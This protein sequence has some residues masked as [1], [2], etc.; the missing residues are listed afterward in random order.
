MAVAAT[1]FYTRF[2]MSLQHSIGVLG[3]LPRLKTY[4]HVLL[5]FPLPQNR[6]PADIIASLESA[7]TEIVHA[8]PWIAYRVVHEGSDN[9][10]SGTFRLAP[11]H[12]DAPED[13]LHVKDCT[14]ILPAYGKLLES[15]GTVSLLDGSI[16]ATLPAFPQIYSDTELNPAPVFSLQVNIIYGGILLDAAAQHNVID[17]GGVFRILELLAKALRGEPF[18]DDEKKNGN[19]DRSNLIP[20]LLPEEPMLDHSHLLREPLSGAQIVT[21]RPAARWQFVRIPALKVAA[22]KDTANEDVRDAQGTFVSTNDALSA[23]IWKR[24]AIVRH[25]QGQEPNSMSKFSR[26]LDARRAMKIP[27]E[28]LGQ[29]GYNASCYLTFRELY[30]KTTPH[31]VSPRRRLQCTRLQSPAPCNTP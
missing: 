18:S 31:P 19:R 12:F 21:Q 10:S 22:L 6:Q 14:V 2:M 13:I 25:K 4:T 20:L 28:Y 27:R 30:D 5:L 3:Q 9:K 29:M 15:R 24:I 17:G 23:F 8:F 7:I 16:L 1:E 11:G 26:A